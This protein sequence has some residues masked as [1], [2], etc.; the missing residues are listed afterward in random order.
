MKQKNK[1]LSFD[2][3]YSNLYPENWETVKEALLAAENQMIRAC[4]N[5]SPASTTEK[6]LDFPKF[7]SELSA[8]PH[9]RD[10][11]NLKNY[12]V[13]DPASY[14][15]A[16]QLEI[17]PS[18]KVLDMCAAPGGKTLILAESLAGGE[19][20]SNEISPSRRDRLKQVIIDYIPKETRSH[21][22][23]KGKDGLK[24]GIN[25]PDEFDKILLD[26]PCS[27]ERH[28]LKDPKE[29]ETW[30]P[31]RTK[32]LAGIQYGLLCSALLACKSGGE[33]VYSTCSLSPLENDGVIEKLLNKK[34]D[35]VEVITKEVEYFEKTK[36]GN[37]S[38][39]H[40]FGI[41]PIYFC[42]LKKI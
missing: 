11:E 4:F 15:C 32:K 2:E 33:I 20:W 1:K 42:K 36:Y 12:Y 29:L 38:L 5:A 22:F 17:E 31:K 28:V 34:G 21:V 30:G 39:P 9:K 7:S 23:I 40:Q 10:S 37:I 18:D 41:G 35:Q 25:F 8:L 3:Y 19:L 13:M 26:A 6:I 14:I 16:S 27:S 24:Y